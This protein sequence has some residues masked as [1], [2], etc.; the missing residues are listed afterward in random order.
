M[1]DPLNILMITHHR[2]YR[3]SGRSLIMAKH[4]VDRGHHVTLCV[5]ADTR[6]FGTVS[7]LNGALRIVE[8]PDLLWGKLRSGWDLWSYINRDIYLSRYQE[9]CDLIHCFETRPNSIYPA[10]H[11]SHHRNIP[12]ITDWNDWFG[13]GGLIEVLRP[14]WYKILLG[15]FETYFEEAYRKQADGLTVISTALAD[16]AIRLGVSPD[17]ICRITGG[18]SPEIYPYRSKNECRNHMSYA[19]DWPILGFCSSDSYLDTEIIIYSLAILRKKYPHIRLILTGDVKRSIIDTARQAGVEEN[20][21]LPGYLPIKELSWCLGSSDIFLLPFPATIYNLGRWPNKIGLY[22]C[23][24]RPI[25]SN[26]VGDIQPL[27]GDNPIGLAAEYTPEDF[28]SKCT[29]LLENPEL[30]RQMGETAK[31][32]ADTAFN[33]KIKIID[34]ESFYYQILGERAV[35][36]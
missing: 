4:L 29:E 9:P 35:T 2:K 27:F 1:T 15:G 17:K 20:L 23:Q 32:L 14:R 16:R 19:L 36:G 13:R 3:T 18:A 30:S 8:F 21:I 28:A 5:T 7:T 12:L 10:L 25:V 33:W 6:R 24:G 22:M 26:S 11:F 31:R 34:L